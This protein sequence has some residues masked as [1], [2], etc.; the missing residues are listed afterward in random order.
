MRRRSDVAFGP[1]DMNAVKEFEDVLKS[2]GNP[3]QK[4]YENLRKE[5]IQLYVA[6]HSNT[7]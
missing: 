3:L 4:H 7:N 2:N 5:R 1:C 6:K